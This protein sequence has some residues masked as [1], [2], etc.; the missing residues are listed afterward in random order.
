MQR[1]ELENKITLHGRGVI[2]GNA[3]GAAL[4]VQDSIQGWSGIDP[5]TGEI[6]EKGHPLEGYRIKN[7]VLIVNGGKG[8][9]GWAT[10][11]HELRVGGI[12]PI[13][14]IFPQID[15]RTAAAAV[16]SKVPCVTDMQEDPFALV[17]TGDWVKVDG[18][19]GVVEVFRSLCDPS[20]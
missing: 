5:R 3:E 1:P 15:S 17:T 20:R 8:S 16:M 14:M 2:G 11:F 4:V 7:A 18:T 13:A 6:V 9:T 19:H 12:G 10:H